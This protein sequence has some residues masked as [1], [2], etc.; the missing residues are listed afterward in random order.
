MRCLL[1]PAVR[2][3]NKL[4]YVYKFAL[5]GLL[6]V[7]QSTVLI[8]MLTA[9]L[10]KNIDFAAKERLG[11]MYGRA[12]VI[13]LNEA[14]GY[15]SIHYAYAL[16]DRTQAEALREKQAKVD[17][18]LEAVAAVDRFIGAEL[19]TTWKLQVLRSEWDTRK[20]E[21]DQFEPERAYVAFE[22]HSRWLSQITGLMQQ[23]GNA[24]N[25]ALD[26]DLNTAY[27]CDEVLRK[28]PLLIDALGQAEGLSGQLPG[29]GQVMPADRDRLLAVA[30]LVRSTLQQADQNSQ[31]V[32]RRNEAVKAKLKPF[33]DAAVDAVPIFIWNIE[34]KADNKARNIPRELLKSAGNRALATTLT[35][36]DK[37]LSEIERLIDV[38]IAGY[39]RYR[40]TITAFTVGI[41]LLVCYLFLAF[42]MSVRKKVYD[43]NSVM[44]SVAKGDLGMRGKVNSQDEMGALT[45]AVNNMLGSLETMYEEVRQSRDRLEI[46]NQQLE[47]K[48]AA[49]TA[50]LRNLLDHA[51][52]G[53]L[54][55]GD[56]LRVAGEYSA[57]CRSIFGREISGLTVPIL[58][59]PDDKDQQT[60]L[61]ALFRKIFTERDRFLRDTYFSLLPDELVIDGQ[62]IGIAYKLINN[63]SAAGRP[64]IMLILT[65]RTEKKALEEQMEEEKNVLAMVVRVVT[66]AGDFFAS[67]R[68]YTTFCREEMPDILA[69]AASPED[70]L[71]TIFR[72]VHTFKGTFGQ[73]GMRG[74]V[75]ELHTLEGI[76]TKLRA[77]EPGDGPPDEPATALAL[78]Q[79]ATMLA[80]LDED[81]G[82]L[83]DILGDSFF[84]QEDTLV[85]DSTKLLDI[86]ERIERI[87][88]PAE[89]R[90]LIPALRSLRHK[91]LR[92]LLKVYP[93]YVGN[94]AEKYGK[95][96]NPLII[97]GGE[98][99]IDPLKYYNFTK[100]LGHIFRNAIVHGLETPD[101][102]LAA[103]KDERG[104][105]TC[106]ISE[107]EDGLFIC[108]ADDGRGIDPDRIRAVA[109]SK[110][111]CDERTASAMTS[112]EAIELIFADGFSGAEEVSELAG[113]GVGLSAVRNELEKMGGFITV[114]SVVGG[115]T[116]FKCFLPVPNPQNQIPETLLEA[117]KPLLD[118]AKDYLQKNTGLTVG[119]WKYCDR[120]SDGKLPLLKITTFVDVKGVVNGKLVLSADEAVVIRMA[121]ARGKSSTTPAEKW[122]ESVLASCAHEVFGDALAKVRQWDDAVKADAVVTILAEDASAKYPQTDVLTWSQ[123]TAV[124]RLNLSLLY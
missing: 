65:D 68:Q 77:E 9:E 58:F 26:T 88:T 66:H 87:L 59:Y 6:I 29:S 2:G 22:L 82:T 89:C 32:F 47:A 108:I 54:S 17:A 45:Q 52:Q 70:K 31:T 64:E 99:S 86:E 95:V 73:L 100:A 27:L 61:E 74:I 78:Y 83:K 115:G 24:S 18:A 4:K 103:G 117:A 109:V 121:A 56:D 14:Q 15:R 57:E 102:R 13:L 33:N 92:E 76:L 72:V 110:G 116:G 93:E 1:E 12:L 16:G 114:E 122:L 112:D 43:L 80:W 50:S 91:P 34:Q 5:I 79:P 10:N 90:L 28:L 41:L 85:V 118:T 98:T 67:V 25:L 20:R 8:Y 84:A 94:L 120:P 62:N 48:V 113:R 111:I 30:G 104:T 97:E 69:S 75:R 3:M 40:N 123:E 106:R 55:F 46:W 107:Q 96:I 49:R 36:F 7:I 42:D 19:E 119:E 23:A 51:G 11:L 101:E 44:D 81:I 105:I 39:T 124:G 53:F 38:R 37:E 35:L 21:A 60:F 71:A 63:R